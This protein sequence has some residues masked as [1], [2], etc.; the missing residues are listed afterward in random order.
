M[1]VSIE[2]R[3]WLRGVWK[4][5]SDTLPCTESSRMRLRLLVSA[6]SWSASRMVVLRRRK[7]ILLCPPGTETRPWR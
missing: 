4:K 7:V 3:I 2:S 6:M 1:A 5:S